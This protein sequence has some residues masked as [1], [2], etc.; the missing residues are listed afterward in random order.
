[1]DRTLLETLP[2]PQRLALSY[3]P[4]AARAPTLALLA[5]DARLGA[6][7]RQ[8]REPVLVQMRLAW[9]RDTLGSPAS[10]WPSG[11]AVL[12]ALRGWR[13]PEALAPL[14][15]GWEALLG[16]DLDEAAMRAF[17][18]GRGEAFGQLARELGHD[19]GAANACARQWALGDLAA[20]LS[21][22]GERAAVIELAA[23]LPPSA[24]LPRALR[25]LAVLAGLARRSL[26][27]GGAPLLDGPGALLHAVRLGITGR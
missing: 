12:D 13:A 27:R 17:A 21:D 10:A 20:N 2:P 8:R 7:V 23:G 9:W 3:A 11:E 26:A 15:D 14:V 24:R 5:L 4:P 25:P 18:G 1:M 16:E 6:A 22:P 19:P